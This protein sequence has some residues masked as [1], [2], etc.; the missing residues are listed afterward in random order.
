MDGYP[1]YGPRARIL[2]GVATNA[3]LDECHGRNFG[4]GLGYRYI[5]NNEYPYTVGCLRGQLR[6]SV[7]CSS[8]TINLTNLS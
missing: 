3:D 1:I 7:E 5:I 4:D 6:H 8:K 2:R